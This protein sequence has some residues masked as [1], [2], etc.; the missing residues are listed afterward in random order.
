MDFRNENVV[1]AL[2]LGLADAMLRVAQAEAPESGPAAAALALLGHEPGMS[3]E[4]LR[5]SL[6]LSHPGA[7]RLVDRLAENGLVVRGASASDRR[8][9]ELRLTAAGEATCRAVI[10]A[11]DRAIARAM[12]SLT[13]EEQQTFGALA[14][15]MLRGF[16]A[17]LDHAYAVCRLC[18]YDACS[19]CPVE[20]E[21]ACRQIQV[22][23]DT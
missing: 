19:N 17:D 1:G 21:L 14:E 22:G 10:A 7:V 5:R 6:G 4:R 16:V 3:I 2:V 9:V 11:R 23:A 18:D 20:D 13:A 15:K 12:T 8:A